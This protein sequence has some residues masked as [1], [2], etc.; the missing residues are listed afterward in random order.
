MNWTIQRTAVPSILSGT[1]ICMIVLRTLSNSS[2]VSRGVAAQQQDE[3]E[4]QH[5]R[6]DRP[7]RAVEE[8]QQEHDGAAFISQT[9]A[10]CTK[11]GTAMPDIGSG[12]VLRSSATPQMI[13]STPR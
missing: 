5:Q 9:T 1:A 12:C 11:P 4:Q 3:H 13:A 7:D 6:A 2:S 8:Q 10:G